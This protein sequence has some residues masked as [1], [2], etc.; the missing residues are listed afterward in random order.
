MAVQLAKALGASTVAATGSNTELLKSLGADIAIDYH[1]ENW[2]ETLAGQ[3][4]DV[5]FAT[6]ADGDDSAERALGVLGPKGSFIYTLDK[7]ALKDKE[8]PDI[9][10]RTFKYMLT[11]STDATSLVKIA[12]FVMDGKVKP[13][14][15]QDKTFPFTPEGW[16]ALI[17][18]AASGRAKGK[19]VMDLK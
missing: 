4:Y 9:G 10:D 13:L 6:V 17:K 18:D 5:I 16:G 11:E 8:N 14:L 3:D 19:L 12:Q 15:H 7:T 2:G 1:N